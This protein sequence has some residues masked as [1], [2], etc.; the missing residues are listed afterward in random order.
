[1]VDGDVEDPVL[2]ECAE[3]IR[4]EVHDR[5][6]AGHGDPAA[7]V[8]DLYWDWAPVIDND[9]GCEELTALLERA[10][11]G[12]VAAMR[13][14]QDTWP[15]VTDCD[16][17]DEALAAVARGGVL[18]LRYLQD[19]DEVLDE[20]RRAREEGR[21]FRGTVSLHAKAVHA[22]V[23]TGILDVEFSAEQHGGQRGFGEELVRTFRDHGL[24]ATW[25]RG[26]G[27]RSRTL[28]V[29]LTWQRRLPGPGSGGA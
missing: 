21:Q 17:L 19:G 11:A 14:E 12:E 16:R 3:E 15:P 23:R 13:A 8:Q 25:D 10:T 5:V 1:M 6:R 2:S 4:A 20:R 9:L 24:D 27:V 28:Q 29:A 18:V 26:K 22:A 7:V